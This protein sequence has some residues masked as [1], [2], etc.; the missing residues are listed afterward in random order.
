VPV[1]ERGPVGI[2]RTDLAGRQRGE[3]GPTGGGQVGGQAYADVG[4]QRRPPGCPLLDDVNASPRL[5]SVI[6]SVIS[7][8]AALSSE[9]SQLHQSLWPN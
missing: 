7:R 8:E 4:D 9:V 1:D 6:I 5:S 2:Q 3:D